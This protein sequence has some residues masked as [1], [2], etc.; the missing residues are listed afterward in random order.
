VDSERFFF[1]G[2][3][4]S[5]FLL[6][7]NLCSLSPHV[8]KVVGNPPFSHASRFSFL[9]V[10]LRTAPFY[11]FFLPSVS[12]RNF[13]FLVLL[14]FPSPLGR[15]VMIEK[16]VAFSFSHTKAP[17]RLSFFFSLSH[18]YCTRKTLDAFDQRFFLRFPPR[19]LPW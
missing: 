12:L 19:F 18:T 3:F 15:A 17:L 5:P 13:Q 8:R 2:L 9:A 14:L 10:G 11:L 7:I 4:F 16:L 1:P 6:P